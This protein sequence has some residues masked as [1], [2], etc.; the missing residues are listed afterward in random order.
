MIDFTEKVR[1]NKEADKTLE[2]I[3]SK[4]YDT[5]DLYSE[6]SKITDL[7]VAKMVI[8]RLLDKLA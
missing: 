1:I 5:F 7:E 2:A 8:K 4:R 3:L 6:V